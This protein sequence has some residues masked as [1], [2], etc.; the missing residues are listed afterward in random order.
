MNA[1]LVWCRL[2]FISSFVLLFSFLFFLHKQTPDKQ[3][4]HFQ[5]SNAVL[6]RLDKGEDDEESD[7]KSEYNEARLR[8]ELKMLRNP[9]T[10]TIPAN[11]RQIE[12]EAAST[13]PEK[14]RFYDP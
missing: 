2:L 10:G 12:L 8:H 11:Y 7:A 14:Q 9:V 13:I 3:P 5:V 4:L 1:K 6:N